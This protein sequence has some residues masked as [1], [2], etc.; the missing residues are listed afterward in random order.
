MTR[1]LDLSFKIVIVNTVCMIVIL[2]S[3]FTNIF[4]TCT[5]ADFATTNTSSIRFSFMSRHC[6]DGVAGYI[7]YLNNSNVMAK[8]AYDG[9][10]T[11]KH[12]S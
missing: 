12:A 8:R 1:I 6:I 7:Q 10:Y 11:W 5:D 4:W 2:L 9:K 3:S